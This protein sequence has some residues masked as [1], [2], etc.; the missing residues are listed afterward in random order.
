MNNLDKDQNNVFQQD[1]H[2]TFAKKMDINKDDSN[3]CFNNQTY[4]RKR[5]R[6]AITPDKRNIIEI[7]RKVNNI[8]L[9]YPT[10]PE[11]LKELYTLDEKKRHLQYQLQKEKK[12]QEEKVC[13]SFKPKIDQ[14]SEKMVNNHNNELV[15]RNWEWLKNKEKKIYGK[16]QLKEEIECERDRRN[17]MPLEDLPKAKINV[18]SKV[19]QFLDNGYYRLKNNRSPLNKAR[20]HSPLIPISSYK[21]KNDLTNNRSRIISSIKL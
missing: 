12:E 19:K 5:T 14:L 2:C 13:Y 3:K 15:T 7:Q 10:I 17:M 18:E 9:N 6:Y 20:S 1:R 21:S 16:K 11:H 8:K 4:K